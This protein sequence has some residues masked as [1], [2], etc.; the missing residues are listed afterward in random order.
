MERSS[1]PVARQLCVLALL[2]GLV[3]MHGLT[4]PGDGCHGGTGLPTAVT[5]TMTTMPAGDFAA[6]RLVA[7]MQGMGS[8]CVFVQSAG[9]P[10]MALALLA[11]AG[12]AV[13]SGGSSRTATRADRGRSPPLAGVSLLRQVC[14]SLT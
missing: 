10:A 3:G 13:G 5:A 7:A 12:S 4:A 6:P 9:W 2:L 14:V 8:V 11:I 1:K